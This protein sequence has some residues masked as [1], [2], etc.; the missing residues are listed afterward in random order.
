MVR[1]SESACA[2]LLLLVVVATPLGA[3]QDDSLPGPRYLYLR[4][5]ED[6]GY[7]DGAEGS[8]R[9]DAFDPLKR[10][11]L[12]QVVH[13]RL[14]GEARVRYEVER[15]KFLAPGSQGVDGFLLSRAALHADL[16]VGGRAR[17]FVEGIHADVTDRDERLFF[18]HRNRLDL[19]QAFADVR[20]L[21]AA[22]ELELRMG[23][24]E[25]AYGGQRVVSA[26]GWG[27]M[28]KRVEAV[29]A[30]WEGQWWA[31]DGWWGRPVVTRT[32]DADEGDDE[33]TFAGLYLR[34]R[35]VERHE[36]DGYL[37]QWSDEG[38][39]PSPDGRVGSRSVTTLGV[40]FAG[41]TG[42]ADYELE[43]AAQPFGDWAGG[44]VRAW[45]AGGHLGWTLARLPFLPR[46]AVRFEW[47][48]GDDEPDDGR[49]GTFDQLYRQE[50]DHLGYL[51]LFGR[52]NI[53][54]VNATVGAWL[55]PRRLRLDAFL[56]SFWLDADADAVY[57]PGGLPAPGRRDP[58]GESGSHVGRELDLT[59]GWIV[60]AHSQVLLG[61]MHFWNGEYVWRTGPASAPRGFQLQWQFRF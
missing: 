24:Q 59:L 3:S 36:L 52:Q 32:V 9:P 50:K 51:A 21:S 14:G 2:L 19:H 22:P 26:S 55:K 29:K 44:E 60:D 53:R 27:R 7:L 11:R 46:A 23:R 30:M 18:I 45:S 54:T 48:S 56:Y 47:A 35:P 40:R 6:F 4:Y 1:R 58:G 43:V 8:Y 28:R 20:P 34:T 39:P 25:L 12:G 33:A 10:I 49:I 5:D 37:L 15:N 13:L 17:V 16:Q 31:L 42:P 38:P 61:Y 41:R 57:N